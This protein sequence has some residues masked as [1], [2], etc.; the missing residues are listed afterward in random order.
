M[1]ALFFLIHAPCT[2]LDTGVGRRKSAGFR[3]EHGARVGVRSPA[4]L[5]P[6]HLRR[7]ARVPGGVAPRNRAQLETRQ[8]LWWLAYP[9]ATL[10]AADRKRGT[11][12]Q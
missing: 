1:R 9:R 4:P 2:N 6:A 11:L 8:T 5:P 10:T 3:S 7:S 12:A